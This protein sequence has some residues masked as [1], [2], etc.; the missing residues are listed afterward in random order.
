MLRLENC[1]RQDI[2]SDMFDQQRPMRF[3]VIGTKV[4]T[5]YEDMRDKDF[6]RAEGH[7]IFIGPELL[8]SGEAWTV[9]IIS[10]GEPEVRLESSYLVGVDVRH[11]V[12]HADSGVALGKRALA[13]VAAT[14]ASTI[15]ALI[16]TLISTLVMK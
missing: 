11:A 5:V 14:G 1:G 16:V 7:Q 3:S 10:D 9:R 12:K 2:T 13:S 4:A 8:R 15:L 6:I